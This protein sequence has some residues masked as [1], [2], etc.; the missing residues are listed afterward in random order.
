[1]A[2][3][4]AAAQNGTWKPPYVLKDQDITKTVQAP[5][6][7]SLQSESIASLKRVLNRTATRG[8]AKSARVSGDVVGVAALATYVRGGDN[9][10]V[11]WFVGSAG[12]R[13]F[14]I[15][16][17]GRVNTAKL[18]AKFLTGHS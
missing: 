15:A 18:A 4:A 5:A 10:T 16:V 11:S 17:E 13:A 7:Q 3:V 9:K 2:L 14:A 8:N 12:D 1:M 6:P